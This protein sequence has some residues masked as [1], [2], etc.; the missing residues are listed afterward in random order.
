MWTF[1]AWWRMSKPTRRSLFGND[2]LISFIQTTQLENNWIPIGC[3]V[4]NL[5]VK[6]FPSAALKCSS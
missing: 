4:T 3:L 5:V 2:E 6:I 1:L